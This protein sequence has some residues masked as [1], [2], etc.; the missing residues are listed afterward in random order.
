R[1]DIP[2][3]RCGH[4][5]TH[6]RCASRQTVLRYRARRLKMLVPA[7][8]GGR[9]A[10][11]PPCSIARPRRHCGRLSAPDRSAMTA[12]ARRG[13]IMPEVDFLAKYQKATK[14][15]Y[16]AR[17]VEH[18]KAECAAVAKKWGEEYW[19]GPRQ[20]GYGGYKYDGRWLPIAEDIARH[21][22]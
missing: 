2:S 20:Y 9:I 5:R 16:V 18:D 7:G 11:S 10:V 22:G 3:R 4:E 8:C 14:R 17:V 1:R 19:D 13:Q 15:D 6:A 21:Y 12:R